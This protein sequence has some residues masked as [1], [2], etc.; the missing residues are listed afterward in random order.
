MEIIC[1]ANGSASAL[2]KLNAL[3][4]F[5]MAYFSSEREKA[6]HF[7]MER[8]SDWHR[9]HDRVDRVR[10]GLYSVAA[11]NGVSSFQYCDCYVKA[12]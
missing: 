8:R 4:A 11:T 10:L 7:V 2:I 1:D 3:Y 6:S 12:S 9:S 5:H